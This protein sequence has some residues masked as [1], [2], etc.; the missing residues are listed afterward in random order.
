MAIPKMTDDLAVIQK[1]SDLPNT[2]DGLT[3][4]DLKAKFDEAALTIQAYLNKMLVPA[5]QA[6]NIPFTETNAIRAATIQAAIEDVQAQIVRAS[7]GN[8][9]N[10]SVTK[11]KLAAALLER[12]YGGLA[13]VSAETPG[14]K[15]NPAADFPI[16]QI[17]L[18]PSFTVS[19]LMNATSWTGTG[20]DVDVSGANVK[21]TGKSQAAVAT[22][23][24]TITNAGQSGDRVKILFTVENKGTDIEEIT[25]KVNSGAETAVTGKTVLD[26]SLST[27]GSISVVF[28]VTWPAAAMADGSVTFARYTV[29]NLDAMMRQ[30][31]DA[32]EPR[33]WDEY[34]WNTVPEGFISYY[35][36]DALFIQEKTGMWEQIAFDTLPIS[37]GGTGLTQLQKSRY[38]K[39]DADGAFTFLSG[40]DVVNDLGIVKM[41]T[42]EY[43]GNGLSRT[44]TLPVTPKL[45]HIFSTEGPHNGNGGSNGT[46]DNPITLGNGAKKA[47]YW[48]ETNTSSEN[49]NASS[50][51]TNHAVE[52]SGNSLK[53]SY[54]VG[55]I[56][57]TAS[58]HARLGNREN[59]TYKWIA[60]Y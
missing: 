33:D 40:E 18:R 52:L 25:I 6:E 13:W 8:I 58:G 42:G 17:W 2:E 39:T 15:D 11:E 1:L 16:G 3:A 48:S 24:Q 51:Q 46:Y 38:V 35:S 30:M 9:T 31:T 49:P 14:A 10:G 23:A 29:V 54:A 19:N 36:A 60:L 32:R 21:L 7:E 4:D 57:G 5:V 59:V 55:T 56:G 53:F 47:E 45:L 20:C 50:Y 22:A 34:L 26:A 12:V 43:I 28:S 41:A 27:G 44:L 37:R